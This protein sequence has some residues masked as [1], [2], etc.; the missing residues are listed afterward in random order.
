MFQLISIYLNTISRNGERFLVIKIADPT[1]SLDFGAKVSLSEVDKEEVGKRNIKVIALVVTHLRAAGKQNCPIKVETIPIGF[2]LDGSDNQV[3]PEQSIIRMF[4]NDE[5]E[6]AFDV[7]DH[8]EP[9]DRRLQPS[10]QDEPRPA[11]RRHRG[12]G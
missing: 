7:A 10:P 2:Q 1:E 5:V 8:G 11:D 9:Q 6:G 12:G 3:V 4:D